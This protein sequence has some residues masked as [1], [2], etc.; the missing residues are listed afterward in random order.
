QEG[1]N[2]VALCGDGTTSVTATCIDAATCDM[3]CKNDCNKVCATHMSCKTSECTTPCGSTTTTSVTSTTT[4]T[5]G[6]VNCVAHCADGTTSVTATCIHAATCDMFCKNDCNKVCATHM[7][8][9]TSEC[10]TPC[11]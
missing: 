2:C 5:Q 9:K 11:G 6:G 8:C 4:T 3:F 1:V 10:T 7:S